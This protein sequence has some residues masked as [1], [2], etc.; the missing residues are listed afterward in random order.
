VTT[1]LHVPSVCDQLAHFQQGNH[2]G[3]SALNAIGEA[4]LKYFLCARAQSFEVF[5][6]WD[7]NVATPALT[8]DGR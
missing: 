2:H 1:R 3:A 7:K 4:A 8:K 6:W 5:R